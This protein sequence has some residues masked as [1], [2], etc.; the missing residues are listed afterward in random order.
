MGEME[1]R[2][3]SVR[4][5]T[6]E[7]IVQMLRVACVTK[8]DGFRGTEVALMAARPQ[9]GPIT[10]HGSVRFHG[11]QPKISCSWPIEVAR[12]LARLLLCPTWRP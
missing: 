2:G 4:G 3:Y 1:R 9:A 12:S 8:T 5:K 7:Q 6:D 10:E 11:R